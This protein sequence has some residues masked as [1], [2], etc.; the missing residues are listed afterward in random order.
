M[1]KSLS[2]RKLRTAQIC[3]AAVL[4]LLGS[5]LR[6]QS[7]APE[8]SAPAR[9]D[10][11]SAFPAKWVFTASTTNRYHDAWI[12]GNRLPATSGGP[13][14]ISAV[15][16]GTGTGED[17]LRT[18]HTNKPAVSTLTEGDYWLYTLPVERL[19]AGS[20]VEF[21]A[22]MAGNAASPE[23]FIVEF[24][25]DGAWKSVGEDLLAAAEDPSLRYTYRCSGVSSGARYQYANVMQSYRFTRPVDGAV[26]IRCRAVGP[27]TCRRDTAARTTGNASSLLP[28]FGFT[29]S[30]VQDLGRA[31]PQ[32]TLNV[33][34]IGNSFSYYGNPAWMLKEI[35]WNE[36]HYLKIRGHFKGG[37]RFGQHLNLPFTAHA[38]DYGGY[39]YAFIQDQSQQ[40]AIFGRDGTKAI[41]SCCT[42]LANRIRTASPAC[43]V[44]LEQTWSFQAD[45]YGGF[46]SFAAFDN[47]ASAGVRAMAEA[48]GTGISPIGRAFGIVR[49]EAPKIDL[50]HKDRKHQSLC[51][52][53]LKACVNYLVLFRKPFG[54]APADCGID[55][56][57][58]AY[59]RRVA[60]T[61][62]LKHPNA[63][64]VQAASYTE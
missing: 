22:T 5:P 45:D 33:L 17:L 1:N 44:I 10:T 24:F 42:A 46:G 15:R 48:A 31:I 57:T 62:V 25:D 58:A 32:D 29:A 49:D 61:V 2:F 23:Y 28:S 56:P 63:C 6:A 3:C 9:S 54:P 64:P 16:G 47:Y 53:Y 50:Y 37:Q 13:G 20:V 18:F 38:I 8:T 59:L 41:D 11:L 40:P 19:E 51:G 30:Y 55:A 52:A 14:F 12:A 43:H 60:E 21:D 27:Y 39:D 4:C 36:G 34:C 7:V 26:R 35:A